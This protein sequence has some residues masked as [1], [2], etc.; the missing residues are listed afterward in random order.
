MEAKIF[1]QKFQNH[2]NGCFIGKHISLEGKALTIYV[3]ASSPISTET[4]SL[5]AKITNQIDN[6]V[7]QSKV[8]LAEC[9]TV[10]NRYREKIVEYMEYVLTECKG[11]EFDNVV[12]KFNKKYGEISIDDFINGLKVDVISISIESNSVAI[13]FQYDGT[14][15]EKW[16]VRYDLDLN[17][18][19]MTCES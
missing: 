12:D 3:F 19:E 5:I 15:D 2:G 7:V 16:V 10:G 13:D 8:Q 1:D 11:Y 14:V 6:I 17:F 9:A 18:I 4:K